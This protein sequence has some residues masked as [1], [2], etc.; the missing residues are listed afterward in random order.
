MP[1]VISKMLTA[2][3]GITDRIDMG[4]GFAGFVSQSVQRHANGDWGDLSDFD[5]SLN[6]SALT[7][8]TRI[9]SAYE[10]PTFPKIWIITEADRSVTT[11]LFPSE[12]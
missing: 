9:L 5:K 1:K 11:V 4:G 10:H 7:D 2:T 3:S 6:D 12:Y 8:G